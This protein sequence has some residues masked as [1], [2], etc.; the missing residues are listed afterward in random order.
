MDLSRSPAR[1]VATPDAGR[2]GCSAR[3]KGGFLHGTVELVGIDAAE[4]VVKLEGTATF[5][6]DVSG[7]HD[8]LRCP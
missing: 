8:A 1:G 6:I 4:L 2:N 5:D 3:G 7:V